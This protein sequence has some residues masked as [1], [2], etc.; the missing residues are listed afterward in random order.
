VHNVGSHEFSFE[1][2]IVNLGIGGY[3]QAKVGWGEKI[4]GGRRKGVRKVWEVHNA[5]G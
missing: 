3:T 1:M 2:V 4:R 5:E